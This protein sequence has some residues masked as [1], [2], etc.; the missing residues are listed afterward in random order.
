MHRL[1]SLSTRNGEASLTLFGDDDFL[2]AVET[3]LVDSLL[4]TNVHLHSSPD[5]V[6]WVGANT[7]SCSDA[8]GDD[9]VEE[10]EFES[11][12][13][14]L[15]SDVGLGDIVE[16]EVA[17]T[18]DEDSCDGDSETVVNTSNTVSSDGFL[19]DVQKTVELTVFGG[20]T[21]VS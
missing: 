5:S 7:S 19:D 17:S 11:A 18:I 21:H 4:L 1:A 10:S 3:A 15:V 13:L 14:K 2:E 6:D 9:Q 20:L 16:A 12:D 8:V